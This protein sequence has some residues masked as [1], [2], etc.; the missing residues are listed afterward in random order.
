MPPDMFKSQPDRRQASPT[1]LQILGVQTLVVR[2]CPATVV[3]V[4]LRGWPGQLLP[5]DLV[6]DACWPGP[7]QTSPS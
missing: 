2:N 3:I 7:A 5:G 6:G 4:A 1:G